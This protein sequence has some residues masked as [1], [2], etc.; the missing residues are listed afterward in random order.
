MVKPKNSKIDTV[1][2]SLRIG[3]LSA[4]KITHCNKS[5]SNP[6]LWSLEN[7]NVLQKQVKASWFATTIQKSNFLT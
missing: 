6:Q 1:M 4:F 5:Q 2:L 7:I 3:G